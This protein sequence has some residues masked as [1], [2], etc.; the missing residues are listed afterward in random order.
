MIYVAKGDWVR[1]EWLETTSGCLSGS[2]LKV[3]A[4]S[5]SV[6]GTVRHV[7]GDHPT[8]PTSVRL[9]VEPDGGGDLVLVNPTAVAEHRSKG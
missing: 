8:H 4:R 2:Q 6:S 1:A 3:A 9:F 7:R 5:R